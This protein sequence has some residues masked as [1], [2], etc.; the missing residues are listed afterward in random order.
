MPENIILLPLP[1]YA[2]ELN[3]VETIPQSIRRNFLAHK[4]W[5]SYD[6]ILDAGYDA[7]NKLIAR[8]D[9]IRYIGSP[10]WTEVVF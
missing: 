2:P 8:P 10:A 9:M 1:P 3:A 7:W 4:V 6:A 5:E